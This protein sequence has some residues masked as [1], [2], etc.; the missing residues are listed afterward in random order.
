MLA[1]FR[2]FVDLCLF[3]KAPQDVPYS[4][5]LFVLMLSLKVILSLV[6]L[7]MLVEES[8]R[9]EF[10]EAVIFIALRTVLFVV[11]LISIMY[12][13][14]LRNRI[15]QTLTAI[16][17]TDAVFELIF[18]FVGL[19]LSLLPQG[20]P[21]FIIVIMLYLGWKLAVQSNI[22]RYAMSISLLTAGFLA[23]GLFFLEILIEKKFSPVLM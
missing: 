6:Y 20:S 4:V 22:Y 8:R 17:G 9:P 11:I 19:A 7:F 18:L 2:L 21:V 10:S 3:R 5:F 13:L 14:G 15:L 16:Q 23:A 1:I 12:I